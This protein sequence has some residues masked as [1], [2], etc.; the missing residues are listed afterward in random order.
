MAV[1]TLSAPAGVGRAIIAPPSQANARNR[2]SPVDVSTAYP[3]TWPRSF[4]AAA[5]VWK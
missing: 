2:M 4:T 5:V 3:T 1:A